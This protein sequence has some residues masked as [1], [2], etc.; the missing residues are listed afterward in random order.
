ML[1]DGEAI[2]ELMIDHGIG[3]IKQPLLLYEVAPEFFEFEED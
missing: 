2:T 1:L 3:V